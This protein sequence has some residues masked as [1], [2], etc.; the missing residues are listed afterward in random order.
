MK[1]KRRKKLMKRKIMIKKIVKGK[2][3]CIRVIK[4][5]NLKNGVKEKRVRLK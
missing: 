5:L 4:K 1:I 2:G 3:I